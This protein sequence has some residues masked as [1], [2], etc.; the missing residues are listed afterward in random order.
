VVVKLRERER[1]REREKVAVCKQAMQMFD[2]ERFN[3]M[4]LNHETVLK[5]Y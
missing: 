4:K 2:M 1:E 3:L 5:N